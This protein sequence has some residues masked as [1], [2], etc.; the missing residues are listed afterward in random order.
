MISRLSPAP[1]SCGAFWAPASNCRE[2]QCQHFFRSG[3][4]LPPLHLTP[5]LLS[6][7]MSVYAAGQEEPK[8]PGTQPLALSTD[9]FVPVR[10]G[11]PPPGTV[12][13][14][15]V[16][17]GESKPKLFESAQLPVTKTLTLKNRIVV[18]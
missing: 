10:Q 11:H 4:P 17:E 18:R 9:R 12:P 16:P 3:P 2:R 15:I 13:D 14:E 7:T 8:W 5:S 1:F 6:P